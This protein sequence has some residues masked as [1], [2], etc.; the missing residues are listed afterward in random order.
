MNNVQNLTKE[1]VV[2]IEGGTFNFNP[3][4]DILDPIKNHKGEWIGIVPK[5]EGP[6]F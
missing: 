2:A 1:E 5:E 6:I 4:G 3:T